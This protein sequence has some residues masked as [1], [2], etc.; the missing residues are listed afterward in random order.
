MPKHSDSAMAGSSAYAIVESLTT[1]VRPRLAGLREARAR[2]WAV[3]T[4]RWLGLENVRIETFE[5]PGWER[6]VETGILT[7]PFP[8]PLALTA[9]GSVATDETGLEAEVALFE[10]LEALEEA[11]DNSLDGK[12]AYVSHAMQKTQNGAAYGFYG[13][14]RREGAIIASRKGAS[15]LLIRS[16]GTD[17]HRMPHTGMMRY[18]EEVEKIP[19]A[20]L[21][22]PDADQIERVARRGKPIRIALTLTPRFT[23]T[24]KSGNVIGEIPGRERPD[25]VVLIAGHLDS[26]DL[27]TGAVDDG[28]GVAIAAAAARQILDAGRAPRRTIRVVFY[29]AE[30]VGLLGGFAYLDDHSDVLEKH[31]IGTESDFGA[32][33]SWQMRAGV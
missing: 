8:Q 29:G 2:A 33:R 19:A 31:I 14:A 9:L 17:S 23:G 27:G 22:N 18:S 10:S 21:S 26:W 5:M 3:E 7:A 11:P 1:E 4:M 32:E 24:V 15:A 20:A 25:E 16:I 28:A 13:R 12:I 30:E 6:G